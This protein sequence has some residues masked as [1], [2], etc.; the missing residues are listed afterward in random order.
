[1]S[2]TP[3]NKDFELTYLDL[4][5]VASS[6]LFSALTRQTAAWCMKETYITIASWLQAL[7]SDDLRALINQVDR[8]VSFNESLDTIK[9]IA[10]ILSVAEG[11]EIPATSQDLWVAVNRFIVVITAE[12]LSRKGLGKVNYEKVTLSTDLAPGDI[13]TLTLPQSVLDNLTNPQ[14]TDTPAKDDPSDPMFPLGK[15]T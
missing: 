6:S 8:H 14:P 4:N 5:H 1:M 9:V 15:P 2:E 12:S 10:S 11:G 7:H 13:L 3:W